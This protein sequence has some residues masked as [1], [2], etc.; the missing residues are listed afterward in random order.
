VVDTVMKNK[1]ARAKSVAEKKT[2]I[3]SLMLLYD[4]RIENFG[5][6]R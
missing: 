4:L 5:D 1:I 6:P 2:Y 3:D